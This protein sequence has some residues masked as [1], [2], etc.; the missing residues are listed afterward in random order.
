LYELLEIDDNA[1]ESQIKKAY[2]RLSVV[3]HPDKNR[4][5]GR[6]TNE[7]WE[8][9]DVDTLCPEK[10]RITD[11]AD[12]K[13]AHGA[14]KLSGRVH[15]LP[16]STPSFPQGC[17]MLPNGLKLHFNKHEGGAASRDA[18]PICRSSGREALKRFNAIRDAYEILSNPIKRVLYDTGGLEAVKQSENGQLEEGENIEQELEVKLQEFYRGKKQFI[19]VRRRVICRRCRKTRDRRRCAGCTPCPGKK[20]YVQRIYGG[21]VHREE[22]TE[23]STEDC[24][25]ENKELEVI[26]ERGSSPGDRVE[27]KHMASQLPNQIPGHVIVNLKEKKPTKASG[28]IRRGDDLQHPV[29]LTLRDSLVGFSRSFKHF[30]NHTVEFSTESITTHGQII[31]IEGEGMPIKDYPGHFGNL[32]LVAEVQYPQYLSKADRDE[33]ME[34]K[35]L[36]KQVLR[37]TPPSPTRKVRDEF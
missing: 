24:R 11:F 5:K 22:R 14:L 23:P 16:L 19:Q 33:L 7:A 8:L 36:Q 21:M 6:T 34:V 10:D 29:R 25:W 31:R 20:F 17:F 32:E 12:C 1:D 37:K 9:Y 30:D 2:R 28:W 27:F 26:V 4:K 15:P 13:T 35:A 18:K 3:Y